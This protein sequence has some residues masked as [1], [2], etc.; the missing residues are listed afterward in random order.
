MVIW[1]DKKKTSKYFQNNKTFSNW[2]YTKCVIYK[3]ILNLH[4]QILEKG[5]GMT[6]DRLPF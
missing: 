6:D 4:R 5:T 3:W 1:D 2:A